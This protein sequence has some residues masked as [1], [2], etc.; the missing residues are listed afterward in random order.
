MGSAARFFSS[1]GNLIFPFIIAKYYDARFLGYFTLFLSVVMFLSYFCRLGMERTII[2]YFSRDGGA[3]GGATQF[4][5]KIFF[6]ASVVVVFLFSFFREYIV[7]FFSDD[8]LVGYLRYGISAVVPYSGIYLVSAYLKSQGRSTVGLLSDPGLVGL[9]MTLVVI[10]MDSVHM[11]PTEYTIVICYTV[12]TWLMLFVVVATVVFNYMPSLSGEFLYKKEFVATS[13][14]FLGIGLMQYVQQICMTFLVGHV[15]DATEVGVVRFAERI[16]LLVPF[17][18]LVINAIYSARFSKLYSK[19]NK[20]TLLLE[21][22]RSTFIS[23]ALGGG[24]IFAILLGW[25]SLMGYFGGEYSGAL[26]FL[27]PLLISQFINVLTGPSDTL[28]G[29]T[30]GERVIFKI[31][32]VSAVLIVP[33]FYVMAAYYSL[34]SAIYAICVVMICRNLL[35]AYFANSVLKKME[36]VC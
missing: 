17:P 33:L 11:L 18:L 12:L 27:Y 9:I 3:A 10:V 35:Q 19:N 25:S 7:G 34:V 15:V 14:V 22:R 36:P 2:K 24:V 8:V 31:A 28:L 4:V 6:F 1:L 23:L 29:M 21:Y 5:L 32:L 20:K 30:G 26:V 13:A 16:S